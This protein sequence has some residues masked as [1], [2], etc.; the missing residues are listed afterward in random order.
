MS[1]KLCLIH[2]VDVDDLCALRI[3]ITPITRHIGSRLALQLR[4]AKVE[5]QLKLYKLYATTPSFRGMTGTLFEG[6]CHGIFQGRIRVKL[7]EMIRLEGGTA[8]R[9]PQ[10]HT[11][12][13]ALHNKTLEKQ[14]QD[15]LGRGID[16]DI[17][18]SG[19]YEYRDGDLTGLS[20]QEVVYYVPS[21]DNKVDLFS[22]ILS[23]GYLYVF[24]MS[25]TRWHGIKG[26]LI[27]L[28]DKCV[29]VPPHD[30]CGLSSSSQ[31]T[32]KF[33]KPHIQ[34]VLK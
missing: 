34:K 5:E 28:L 32:V 9:K 15:A 3:R 17:H 20:I 26:D 16:I 12:Y 4:N 11:I 6:Y 30:I 10:W 29:N 2:R 7:Y 31:M 24:Q 1:H 8:K 22:F 19:T 33:S 18:P 14:R 21:K 25:G 23:G 13:T 27:P